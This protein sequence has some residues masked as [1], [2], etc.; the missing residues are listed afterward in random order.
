MTALEHLIADHRAAYRSDL[1]IS[2]MVSRQPPTTLDLNTGELESEPADANGMNLSAALIRLLGHPEGYGMHHPWL[3]ALWLMRSWCRRAHRR[4]YHSTEEA[5]EG[6][7]C[8]RMVY[9]VIVEGWH[10]RRAGLM[11]NYTD[12]EAILRDA[13]RFLEETLDDFRRQQEQRAKEDEGRQLTC[14]C[15]HSW[16]RHDNPAAMFRCGSCTCTRYNADAKAA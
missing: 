14:I 10:P 5:W 6:S 11:L 13:F 4:R 12:P 9:L 15:G 16:S 2:R 3:K 7:L 1:L 8:H